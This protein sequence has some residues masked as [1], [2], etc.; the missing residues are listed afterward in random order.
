[1]LAWYDNREARGGGG[2]GGALTANLTPAQQAFGITGR[3]ANFTG[4]GIRRITFINNDST[5]FNAAGAYLTGSYNNATVRH[6][7]GSTGVTGSVLRLNDERLVPYEVNGG[8]PGMYRDQKLK[9]FTVTADWQVAQ[10]LFVNLSHNYQKTA[11]EAP[12]R[13]QSFLRG[14]PNTTSRARS[15]TFV[16]ALLRRQLEARLPHGATRGQ[17]L[18]VSRADAKNWHASFAAMGSRGEMDCATL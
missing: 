18:S 9:N 12:E 8:G 4:A 5:V 11:A 6:P 1:V 10:N 7:D 3:N 15:I 13:R 16:G 14:E 2:D 17:R